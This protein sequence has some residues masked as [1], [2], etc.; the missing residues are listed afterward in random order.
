MSITPA[1][2][3]WA[4]VQPHGRSG[5]GPGEPGLSVCRRPL[6]H[7]HHATAINRRWVA[8][9]HLTTVPHVLVPQLLMCSIVRTAGAPT[10]LKEYGDADESTDQ[11]STTPDGR[12]AGAGRRTCGR[13]PLFENL[14]IY[15]DFLHAVVHFVS[16]M[17]LLRI[18]RIQLTGHRGTLRC[19]SNWVVGGDT[20]GYRDNASTQSPTGQGG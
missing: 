6:A 9:D 1:S 4:A 2:S 3:S 19:G 12:S 15:L 8:I 20:A 17:L 10:A 13:R 7:N 11:P 14:L 16:A 5:S 18:T